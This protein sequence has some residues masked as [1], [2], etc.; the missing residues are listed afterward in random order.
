MQGG[1]WVQVFD[2][3]K[4][5]VNI[6]AESVLQGHRDKQGL[7]RV[8]IDNKEYVSLNND[9]LA[10]AINNVFGLQS[11]EQ[12]IIY[13]HACIGFPTKRTWLKAIKKG[14]FVG[15]PLVTRENVSKY[16]PQSEETEKGHRN[17]KQQGIRSTKPKKSSL[18]EPDTSQEVGKKKR[19]VYSKV[20]D[21]WEMKGTIYTDQ[22]GNSLPR[23]E[24][25]TDTA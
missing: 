21:L 2:A 16:F 9:E 12:T 22:T 13:L 20:V 7:W 3:N 6:T 19:D 5:K 24:V 23:Q 18:S 1:Q 11:V 14:N 4:V 10:Q 25:E 8:P 15:W 17:H